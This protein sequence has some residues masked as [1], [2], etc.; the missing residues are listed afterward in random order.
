MSRVHVDIISRAHAAVSPCAGSAARARPVC[1]WTLDP[2]GTQA[3][4][5]GQSDTAFEK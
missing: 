1:D 3:S 2:P 5:D 4:L